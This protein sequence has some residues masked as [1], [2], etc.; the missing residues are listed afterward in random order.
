MRIKNNIF[1]RLIAD[2]CYVWDLN[3]QKEFI[4]SNSVFYILDFIKNGNGIILEELLTK[5]ERLLETD[6]RDSIIEF[7]VQLQGKPST[8]STIH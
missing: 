5:I 8:M 6:N 3:N 1:Y 2:E 4:F 7:I